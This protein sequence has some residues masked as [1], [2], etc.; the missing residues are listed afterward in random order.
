MTTLRVWTHWLALPPAP[1]GAPTTRPA[2]LAAYPGVAPQVEVTGAV[3]GFNT[4]WSKTPVVTVWAELAKQNDINV[5]SWGGASWPGSPPGPW[6]PPPAP[7]S[8]DEGYGPAVVAFKVTGVSIALRNVPNTEFIFTVRDPQNNVV[9]TIA[10]GAGTSAPGVYPLALLGGP[11]ANGR[12]IWTVEISRKAGSSVG[13]PKLYIGGPPGNPVGPTYVSP[14]GNTFEG[15]LGIIFEGEEVVCP[16]TKALTA[17]VEVQTP[18]GPVWQPRTSLIGANCVSVGQKVR[19]TANYGAPPPA[20]GT[21]YMWEFDDGSVVPNTQHPTNFAVHSY[22]TAGSYA[23]GVALSGLP[24]PTLLTKSIDVCWAC[25]TKVEIQPPSQPLPVTGC[26][27][28]SAAVAFDVVVTWPA[29]PVPTPSSYAWVVTGPTGKYERTTPTAH[30]SS[31]D[32]WTKTSVTPNLVGPLGL[33]QGGTGYSVSVTVVVAD[34][35]PGCTL[36][37]TRQF[38]VPSCVACPQVSITAPSVSGCAP[39]NAVGTFTAQIVHVAG[40]PVPTG[41]RWT[42]TESASGKQAV[43]VLPGVT[44]TTNSSSP[45]W[46]GPLSTPGGQVDLSA[47]GS[48][49][50][51][52]TAL[53]APGVQFPAGCDPSSANATIT[54]PKCKQP[55]VAS[56]ALTAGT[57]GRIAVV[58]DTAVDPTS[59]STAANFSVSI[60][61]G[62]AQTPAAGTISYNPA[63]RT[64]TLSG[65][66][67]AVGDTATVTVT[68]VT[69]PSGTLT[70]GTPNTTT[71]GIPRPPTVSCLVL[72]VIAVILI[73]LGGIVAIVGACINVPWV[74]AVGAIVMAVGFILFIIWAIICAA[75]TLC[76]VMQTIQCILF[77]ITGTVMP[78][79]AVLLALF[80]SLACGLAAALTGVIWGALH[81]WL[82]FIMRRVGCP[83]LC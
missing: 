48:Y 11:I 20:A 50:V 74:I 7:V 64:T 16:T 1:A 82:S 22:A 80:G 39:L 57:P 18:G 66:A 5:A 4:T 77:V 40:G 46:T 71:C 53:Y 38:T 59:A 63:T 83:P 54:V 67:L 76:S 26:A 44:A 10:P 43:V 79:V 21:Q 36:V 14:Y 15:I 37:D 47:G 45:A 68:G 62:A 73:L 2:S 61:G 41:Y 28:G 9:G 31:A 12:G 3:P 25:P 24:C 51:K 13:E 27:P 6:P 65:F 35:R 30:A 33:G 70:V 8:G 19:L 69:D 52:V 42:V 60:N 55:T 49:V 58:F 32:S 29:G 78:I 81:S 56:C 34:I 72:L 17:E 23:A 75:T